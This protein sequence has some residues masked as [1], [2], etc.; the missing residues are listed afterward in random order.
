MSRNNQ[1]N[2]KGMPL[3]GYTPGDEF[4]S[5]WE[6]HTWQNAPTR[7]TFAAYG[8]GVFIGFEDANLSNKIG[9]IIPVEHAERLGHSLIN[10]ANVARG[11]EQ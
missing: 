1:H 6:H 3:E 8:D 11:R 7:T 2:H 9:I 5:E 10:H 4:I